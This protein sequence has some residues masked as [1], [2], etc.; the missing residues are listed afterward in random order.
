MAIVLGL[1]GEVATALK[2]S[3]TPCPRCPDDLVV[4]EQELW[5]ISLARELDWIGEGWARSEVENMVTNVIGVDIG[6]QSVALVVDVL[7]R[8]CRKAFEEV[9]TNQIPVHLVIWYTHLK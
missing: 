8:W 5:V 4:L 3:A 7:G 2:S 1:V 6:C 9:Q